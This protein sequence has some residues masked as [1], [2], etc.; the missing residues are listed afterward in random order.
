MLITFAIQHRGILGT[1]NVQKYIGLLVII[2]MLIVGVVPIITG[3]INWS[4]YSPLVPLAAAYAPEPGAW[5]IGG[6]TLV[7]GGMFIAAW[8]TYGFETAICYT[9]EFQE[10]EDRHVQ[11]DLLLG[12]AL[13][14]ALH[15][16]AVHLPGRARPRRHAGDADR[17]RLGRRRGHGQR[18][19][20]AAGFITNIM[21]MLMILALL[22][23]IM[24]AMAG[25]SRTL[26]QGSVD[27]WL[28]TLPQPRQRAWRADA[29]HVDRPRLQPGR[30]RHRLRRRDELLLHPRRVELSATSSSTSSTSTPAGSIASTTATSSGRGGRR[31]GCWA[32]ARSSPSSTPCSWAPAPRSGTRWRCGPASSPPRSSSRCSCSATTSRTRAKFPAHMLEDLNLKRRRSRREARPACC[33][34]SRWSPASPSCWSRTGSSSFR[35]EESDHVRLKRGRSCPASTARFANRRSG[36]DR[37]E[38]RCWLLE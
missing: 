1:A 11:G 15:A 32:S 23:S 13:P 33:P 9:S 25:S 38:T 26:Y 36:H 24:T 22:L 20:A 8:S 7:L 17:R 27:G 21:V 30:A 35:G 6:W 34:T 14:A 18:W 12:P 31:P 4:N 16:G 19:S 37:E 29:R 10:P 5:N 2:P 28:P 3:Q